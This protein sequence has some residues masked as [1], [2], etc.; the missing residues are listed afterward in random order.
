MWH[1]GR[2]MELDLRTTLLELFLRF[3][4]C[5]LI[6]MRCYSIS[7]QLCTGFCCAIVMMGGSINHEIYT[8]FCCGCFIFSCMFMRFIYPYPSW[9]LHWLW[10]NLTIALVPV[11]QPCC[12]WVKSTSDIT[13]KEQIMGMILEKYHRVPHNPL[14]PEHQQHK[15]ILDVLQ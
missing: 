8:L 14:V 2:E 1:H 6:V 7:H 15:Y 4:Q 13:Q 5:T 12:I 3:N 11:K 10:G 9:L